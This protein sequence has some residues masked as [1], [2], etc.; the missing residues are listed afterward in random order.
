MNKFSRSS[1]RN[2]HPVKERV[3]VTESC[4]N[5]NLHC[6][7]YFLSNSKSCLFRLINF[8]KFSSTRI[9]PIL[10]SH[11]HAKGSSQHLI[12]GPIGPR[13]FDFHWSWRGAVCFFFIFAVPIQGF[14]IF[15]FKIDLVH[16]TCVQTGPRTCRLWCLDPGSC[17]PI[18]YSNL[19]KIKVKEFY[20]DFVF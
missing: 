12:C 9:I 2:C 3:L 11:I 7:D 18:R 8:V 16:D 6:Q 19:H 17:L 13:F 4:S 14:F 1:G 5:V 10:S 15:W 20:S